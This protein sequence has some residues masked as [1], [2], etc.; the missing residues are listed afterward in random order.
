MRYATFWQRSLGSLVDVL[1]VGLPSVAIT[2]LVVPWSG[3]AAVLLLF[4]L[5]ALWDLYEVYFHARWGQTLGKMVARARVVT[6]DGFPISWRHALLRSSVGMALTLF[7]VLGRTA[8]LCTIPRSEYAGLGWIE[9]RVL[10][11]QADPAYSYLLGHVSEVWYYSELVV[12]LLN[13]ERRAMHDFIA[14][15][16]VIDLRPP[17]RWKHSGKLKL[18]GGVT[19]ELEP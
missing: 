12:M 19:A 17:R 9:L 1:L 7:F 14:G 6:Y 3:L 5:S 8:A 15:T 10:L 18:L 4:A 11:D 13:R 16:A 2:K